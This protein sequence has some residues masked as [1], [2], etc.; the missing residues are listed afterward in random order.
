MQSSRGVSKEQEEL[1]SYRVHGMEHVTEINLILE[2]TE[3]A[4]GKNEVFSSIG[5]YCML[6]VIGFSLLQCYRTVHA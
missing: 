5:R 3:K 4:I 1:V 6:F 2:P